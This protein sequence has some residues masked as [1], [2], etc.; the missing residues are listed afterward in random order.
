M[1]GGDRVAELHGAPG[2]GKSAV[3]RTFAM[4]HAK[5]FPGGRHFVRPTAETPLEALLRLV[6]SNHPTLLVLDDIDSAPVPR[7]AHDLRSLLEHRPNVRVLMTSRI[8]FSP[9][10]GVAFIEMPP[11][12]A[13]VISELIRTQLGLDH[14]AARRITA[15][16]SGNPRAAIA[17]SRRLASGMP[18][19]RILAW[20][21]AQAVPTVLGLDGLPLGPDA[22]ERA[23]FAVQVSEISDELIELLA[24]EPKLLYELPSRR[25][26]ELVAELYARRGFEV[27]LTP[28]SG[29]GGVDVYVV[30]RDDLGTTLQVV[31]CK[32]HAEK[33]RVGV[34]LVRELYGT[35]QAENA[36]AG[37]LLTTSFFTRGAREFESRFQYRLS[38]Q[39]YFTLQELLTTAART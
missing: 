2:S 3:A 4:R 23:R 30:R 22:P 8:K 12:P 5:A 24:R 35:V 27:E 1:A 33:H 21:D 39:D 31:Q 29:D 32:R 19:E 18:L 38:L 11:L 10:D 20:L 7:F 9:F 13:A 15:R 37:I 26:E 14:D 25:F 17:I 6:P 16:V 36:S 28:S 34:G